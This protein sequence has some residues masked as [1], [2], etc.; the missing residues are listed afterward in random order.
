MVNTTLECLK[1]TTDKI[2]V[3]SILMRAGRTLAGVRL[4]PVVSL[5]LQAGSGLKEGRLEIDF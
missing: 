4:S 5:T 1:K 2:K 3:T